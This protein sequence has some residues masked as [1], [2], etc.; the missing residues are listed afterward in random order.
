MHIKTVT[1]KFALIAIISVCCF[2][3]AEISAQT[4]INAFWT[5]FKTA[6][7]KKDKTSAAN[8]A[9]FPISMP[10]GVK[11]IKTKA[12]FSRRY[13]EIFAGEADAAK[14]FKKS[15]LQKVSAKRYEVAC[16]FKDDTIGDGGEPIVYAFELTKT[17]WKFVSLDNINE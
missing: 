15:P 11:S 14:C 16:G 3:A 17:G 6:I 10:Y 2:N 1:V 4:D 7:E 5:K 9:R 12:E 8:L 13:D